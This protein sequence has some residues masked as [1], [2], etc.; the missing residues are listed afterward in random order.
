[1][2]LISNYTDERVAEAVAKERKFFVALLMDAAQV[3]NVYAATNK[4]YPEK[5]AAGVSVD[6]VC[7]GLTSAVLARTASSE[8]MPEAPIAGSKNG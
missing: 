8:P 4:E 7:H 5:V 2:S 1:M 6:K 3:W